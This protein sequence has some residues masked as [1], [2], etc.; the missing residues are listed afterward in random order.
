ML[1]GSLHVHSPWSVAMSARVAVALSE[2]SGPKENMGS[3]S[4]RHHLHM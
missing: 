1:T 4:V 3:K 2:A